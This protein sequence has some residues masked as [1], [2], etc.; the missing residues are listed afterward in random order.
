MGD[1]WIAACQL[2]FGQHTVESYSTKELGMLSLEDAVHV[3]LSKEVI[4]VSKV[5]ENYSKVSATLF[6]ITEEDIKQRG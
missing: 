3:G 6:I 4:S 5:A 2:A 1:S